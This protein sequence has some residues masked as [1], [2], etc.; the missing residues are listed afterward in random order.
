MLLVNSLSAIESVGY[1]DVE[2]VLA[3]CERASMVGTSATSWIEDNRSVQHLSCSHNHH[4][5]IP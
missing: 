2:M 4:S 1:D 3:A 5:S